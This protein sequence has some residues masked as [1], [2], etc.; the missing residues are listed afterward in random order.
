MVN[1]P[2]RRRLALLSLVATML[3]TGARAD[4]L[5]GAALAL[6]GDTI[7]LQ[8]EEVRLLGIDA[9][10]AAQ[11]CWD[12][13]GQVWPC[14]EEAAA[15]LSDKIAGAT[16]ACKGMRRDR[17]QRLIAVCRIGEENLNAWLV[18]AGW[19]LAYRSQSTAYV[20]A[21]EAA[22]EAAIG[23]WAGAFVPPWVWRAKQ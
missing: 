12:A 9:P 10:E 4:V 18:T 15:A 14:G 23:L 20:A 13:A 3:T 16:V 8:S 17:E 2:G 5:E 1:I 21:E 11:T 22:R 7:K 19:A 6:S